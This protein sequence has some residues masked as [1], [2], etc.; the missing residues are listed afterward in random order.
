MIKNNVA[1]VGG[2]ELVEINESG[3]VSSI[4]QPAIL[5]DT[6]GSVSIPSRLSRCMVYQLLPIGMR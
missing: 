1:H 4:V 3:E 5:V 2:G 6:E